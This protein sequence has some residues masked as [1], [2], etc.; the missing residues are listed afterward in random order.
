MFSSIRGVRVI[1]MLKVTSQFVPRQSTLARRSFCEAGC[2][3]LPWHAVAW[4]KAA[5]T[6]ALLTPLLYHGFVFDAFFHV[7]VV[8]GALGL[9]PCVGFEI[10]FAEGDTEVDPHRQGGELRGWESLAVACVKTLEK[11]TGI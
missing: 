6:L 11:D 2:Q 5:R 9:A 10:V 4:A 3:L 8:F 1:R 7:H